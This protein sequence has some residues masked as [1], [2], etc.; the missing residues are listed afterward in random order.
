[1]NPAQQRLLDFLRQEYSSDDSICLLAIA[2][3]ELQHDKL[4]QT[5]L[6]RVRLALTFRGSSGVNPYFDGTDLFVAVTPSETRFAQE[7]EWAD[8]PP[9]REGSPLELALGWVSELAPPFF[10]SPHT[11]IA[12]D[13]G[14]SPNADKPA[15]SSAVNTESWF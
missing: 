12:S 9:L 15:P 5:S 4:N 11:R 13:K 10:V 14:N 1:M 6:F 8:E 7:Q 2:A 3:T